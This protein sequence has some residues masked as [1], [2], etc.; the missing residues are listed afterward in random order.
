M[1]GIMHYETFMM[2]AIVATIIAVV[3]QYYV[4]NSLL[5]RNRSILGVMVSCIMI[6]YSLLFMLHKD[7]DPLYK[8]EYHWFDITSDDNWF[9]LEANRTYSVV[10]IWILSIIFMATSAQKIDGI[11]FGITIA[12][13]AYGVVWASKDAENDDESLIPNNLM[14]NMIFRCCGVFIGIFW[15][16]HFCRMNIERRVQVQPQSGSNTVADDNV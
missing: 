5:G 6:V 14:N 12:Y 3:V 8:D 13:L 16:I 2:V 4:H 11:I 1:T 10:I 9:S 15:L 7:D